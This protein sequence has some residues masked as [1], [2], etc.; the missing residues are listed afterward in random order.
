MK[1]KTNFILLLTVIIFL[2]VNN[3]FYNFYYVF[4]TNLS[5]RMNYHYGYCSKNGFGFINQVNKKYKLTKN[6]KIFNF[7][8]NPNSEWFFYKPNVGYYSNKYILINSNNLTINNNV[9]FDIYLDNERQGN[10]RIL[11]SYENCFFIERLND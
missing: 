4:R 2:I 6:I 8:E 5:D 3:F 11:D 9:I 10:F 7:I 1:K